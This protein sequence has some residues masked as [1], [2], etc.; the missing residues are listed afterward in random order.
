MAAPVGSQ[1]FGEVLP[2][3]E[4]EKDG[5]SVYEENLNDIAVPNIEG[6]NI[7]EAESILKENNLNIII[8]NFQE[9]IDK[10][11]IIVKEQTPKG[12]IIVKEQSNVY[13]NF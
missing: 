6:K 13:V 10:E 5:E 7:K 12:G 1:I 3:L 11:T 8:N 9:G 2:Y 4:I